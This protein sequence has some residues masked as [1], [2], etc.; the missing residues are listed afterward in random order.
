MD[1]CHR[2]VAVVP[3]RQKGADIAGLC[4]FEAGLFLDKH[5]SQHVRLRHLERPTSSFAGSVRKHHALPAD[6]DSSPRF[7]APSG[8]GCSMP[9]LT[10]GG[11]TAMH[12]RSAAP[13]GFFNRTFRT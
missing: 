4:R 12:R 8:T 7:V 6:P 9:P 10:A 5:P 3:H 11:L 2:V 13:P 1:L